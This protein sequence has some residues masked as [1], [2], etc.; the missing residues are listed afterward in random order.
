MKIPIMK[1]VLRRL[2]FLTNAAKFLNFPKII[3]IKMFSIRKIARVK[4]GLIIYFGSQ[5]VF[6]IPVCYFV[7]RR[8]IF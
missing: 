7:I 1:F 5:I 6:A 4:S 8:K 2:N 3:P